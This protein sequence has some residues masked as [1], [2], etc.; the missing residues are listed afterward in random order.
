MTFWSSDT[1]KQ[2]L[3]ALISPCDPAK[4]EQSSY[5]LRIG[6]EIY[7]T[8]DRHNDNSQHTKRSLVANQAFVIPPGQFAFLFTQEKV[9]VPKDA[10]AFISMKAGFKYKG[11]INISGFHVDPGFEGN[12]L[13]SVYNAGPSPIHL[14]QGESCFLIWYAN[15]DKPDSNARK[16]PGFSEIPT[17]VLNEI[18]TDEVYSIQALVQ[19]ISTVETELSEVKD[20]YKSIL[21]WKN[22]I[23]GVLVLLVFLISQVF[24]NLDKINDYKKGFEKIIEEQNKISSTDSNKPTSSQHIEN[25]T[26]QKIKE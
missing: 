24:I 11:L 2:R 26:Q 12:L 5:T 17:K 25:A 15:L 19:K 13:F 10:I 20:Q 16:K 14:Q 23:W 4:I 6:K 7:V 18:S 21:W 8:K 9:K 3:P 22:V 1:L